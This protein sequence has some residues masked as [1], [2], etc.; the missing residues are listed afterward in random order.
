MPLTESDTRAKL[1]DPA[2]HSLGWTENLIRREE[3]AG[4]IEIVD[5]KPRKRAQGRVD[6]VL[7]LQVTLDT[8]PVAVASQFARF[9]KDG[10]EN[11]EIIKT[12]EVMK[13]GG[14]AAL[15]IL[16]KSAEILRET[17]E[18]MFAA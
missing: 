13:A 12:P 9:G 10:L 14:L 7:R 3:T 6:C 5:E 11:R 4:A 15:K 8:Q 16:G 2:L 1:I 18:R 17:K